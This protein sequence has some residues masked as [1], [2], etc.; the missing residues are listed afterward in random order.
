MLIQNG[1]FTFKV[2]KKMW[3][4]IFYIIG[5]MFFARFTD[6][7]LNGEKAKGIAPIIYIIGGLVWPLVFLVIIIRVFI[8]FIDWLFNAKI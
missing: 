4:I 8:T 5:A 3:N 1:K 7:A 6:Y 2:I